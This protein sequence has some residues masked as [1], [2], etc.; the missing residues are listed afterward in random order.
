MPT[1][2]YQLR[3]ISDPVVRMYC[4]ECHRFAQFDHDRLIERLGADQAMPSLLR[5][6]KPCSIGNG[7]SGPQCQLA[8]LD[9]LMP[10]R[11]AAAIARGG[12]PTA[13]HVDWHSR[14]D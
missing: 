7:M 4:P 6:L 1:G 3:D 10:E 14:R 12:L 2:A 8:Y 11:Q 5:V 9:R 13:W